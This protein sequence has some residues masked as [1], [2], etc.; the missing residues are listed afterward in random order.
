MFDKHK[1]AVLAAEFFGTF[2]LATTILAVATG[3]SIALFPALTAG[4]VLTLM[5]MVVGPIS[6][7]HIN[8]AVT[9]ALWAQKK[10]QTTEAVV[11]IA[12]QILAGFAAWMVA[13]WLLDTD[14][15]AAVTGTIDWRV[16]TAEAIGA[17]VFATGIAAALSQKLDGFK[18]AF[19]IGFSLM[20]GILIASLGG[21]GIVN[22]AVAVAAHAYSISYVVG[23]I[24]GAVLG[25]AFYASVLSPAKSKKR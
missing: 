21:S 8:P 20:A 22:P 13:Q 12:A 18:Q 5:V 19:A 7:A 2:V 25:M 3:T 6:G 1:V 10:V 9:I 17:F 16:V 11:Y 15:D 4:L 14:L 23:P 24:V